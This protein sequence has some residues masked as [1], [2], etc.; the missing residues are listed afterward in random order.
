MANITFESSR[1]E[2]R[3]WL[4]ATDYEESEDAK[5]WIWKNEIWRILR[6]RK[7]EYGNLTTFKKAYWWFWSMKMKKGK[8]KI[9]DRMEKFESTENEVWR[10]DIWVELDRFEWSKNRN[11]GESKLNNS[12]N[13]EY[14]KKKN[15]E[16]FG[17]IDLVDW[18]N[19]KTGLL[20]ETDSDFGEPSAARREKNTTGKPRPPEFYRSVLT[21]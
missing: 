12:E 7:E 17:S 3:R 11:I 14:R 19:R 1:K 6:K 15:R 5:W 13:W 9:S 2:R 18:G 16:I 21:A 10:I 20:G 8:T 4:R